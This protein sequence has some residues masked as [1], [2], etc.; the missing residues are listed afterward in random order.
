MKKETRQLVRGD[1]RRGRL[2]HVRGS[3]TALPVPPD[4]QRLSGC[5]SVLLLS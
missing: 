3:V 4:T 2:A 5:V 1:H